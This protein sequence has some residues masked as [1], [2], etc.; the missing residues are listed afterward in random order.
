MHTKS[1]S[2][3]E[4]TFSSNRYSDRP[5]NKDCDGRVRVETW[6]SSC[7]GYEDYKMTC[8]KCQKVWWVDGIDS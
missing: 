6:E 5:H 4:G 7:G 3:S 1:M 2:E 8:E